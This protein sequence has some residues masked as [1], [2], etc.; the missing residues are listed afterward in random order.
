MRDLDYYE[1]AVGLTIAIAGALY[2]IWIRVF[3]PILAV[4]GAKSKADKDKFDE[5]YNVLIGNNGSSILSTVRRMEARQIL[6]EQTH[7]FL[8]TSLDV[9]YWFC[10]EDGK[11]TEISTPLSKLLMRSEAELRGLNWIK[12]VNEDDKDRVIDAWNFSLENGSTFDEIYRF[13]LPTGEYLTVR[14]VVYQITD[15]HNVVNGYFGTLTRHEK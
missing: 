12:Y 9:C 3:S 7:K 6:Q 15:K 2:T 8:M 14:G 11:A 4:I 1:K 5:M 10:D 13:N